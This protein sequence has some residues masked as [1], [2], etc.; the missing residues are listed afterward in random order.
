MTLY[1][2]IEELR[3]RDPRTVVKN[4]FGS[5]HS[6]R[7]NYCNAAFD[8]LEETTIGEMLKNAINL[9]D[10]TQSGYKGGEY[11][12]HGHVTVLIG[13]YGSRGEGIGTYH[14]LYWDMF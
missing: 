8:P 12:M 3:K 10:T 14:F 7:G 2:V 6:D 11:M 5:G 9:L 1:E 13:E 4:G